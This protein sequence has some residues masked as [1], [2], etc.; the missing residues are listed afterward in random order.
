[1]S[2]ID[3][4]ARAGALALAL[5]AGG[6][7]QAQDAVFDFYISGIKAGEMTMSA[8]STA[9]SYSA[10]SSI[11]AAGAVGLVANFFFDGKSSGRIVG[12]KVSPIRYEA[13]SKSPR[14]E[15]K[16]VMDWRNGVPVSVSVVPPR[17]SAPDP[18]TQGGTLDPVSAGLALLGDAAPDTVCDASVDVFDGSRRSRLSLGAP[19]A[20]DGA[21]TCKG[22]YSRI[23]GE[24]QSMSS[25]REFPFEVTFREGGD[26]IARLERVETR[27]Q[28]G[29]AV[30]ERR[31]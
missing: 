1:M 10:T 6:M 20:K 12:G 17:G 30:L 11:R 9:D 23:E 19:V 18:A 28:F 29:K 14:A 5:G 25:R 27:T 21:L 4:T 3:R 16:T 15:R 13:N 7:A 2:W 22:A 8:R 24:A 26:G 31:D